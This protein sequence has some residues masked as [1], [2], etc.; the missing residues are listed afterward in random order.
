MAVLLLCFIESTVYAQCDC[1]V[2]TAAGTE[3]DVS[4]FAGGP[5]AN[6]FF[7][8]PTPAT[9]TSTNTGYEVNDGLV[10][11]LYQDG[12]GVISLLMF[13]DAFGNGTAGSGSLTVDCLGTGTVG[14]V[15]DAGSDGLTSNGMGGFGG[16]FAW[17][18]DQNDGAVIENIGCGQTFTVSGDFTGINN[19]FVVGAGGSPIP[20]GPA[21]DGVTIS[22]G[23][24]IC[25]PSMFEVDAT[26]NQ[27][28]CPTSQDGAIIATATGGTPPYQYVL[29]D[30]AGNQISIQFPNGSNPAVFGGLEEG[31]YT[32]QVTDSQGNLY[33][34][35]ETETEA[36][37]EAQDLPPV[38]NPATVLGCTF[39]DFSA[40]VDL[41]QAEDDITGNDPNLSVLWYEDPDLMFPIPFPPLHTVFGP[42]PTTVYAVATNGICP[43]EPVPIT[44]D[45][46][47]VPF[48]E[49][50]DY[51]EC[52]LGNTSMAT[53]DL[54]EKEDSIT[55]NNVAGG[56]A[57]T[58]N[59]FEDEN[60]MDTIQTPEM[61]ETA[62]TT[63]YVT[64]RGIECESDPVPI[65]LIVLENP[66]GTPD[67]LDECADPSG[68]A[69][70]DLLAAIP[71]IYND[72]GTVT[73]YEDDMQVDSIETPGSYMSASTTV[74]AFITEG[75]CISDPIPVLLNAIISPPGP[76]DM[77]ALCDDGMGMATFDLTNI[78]P[79]LTGSSD[80]IRWYSDAAGTM[81]IADPSMVTAPDTTVYYS[82]FTEGCE[83]PLA[84]VVLD[85]VPSPLVQPDTLNAC[86]DGTGVGFF[87]LTSADIIT[88]GVG[89]VSW[90]E[91]AAQTSPI[92]DPAS[93]TSG[94]TT[95]YAQAAQDSCTSEV[96]A[97]ELQIL[98]VDVA[99]GFSIT[100]CGDQ[101][102]F[103]TFDLTAVEDSIYT[104]PGTVSWFTDPNQLS[105]IANPANFNSPSSTVYGFATEDT[106]T[107]VPVPV[108]LDVIVSTPGPD[109]QISL[110]DDGMGTAEF[111]LT[112][113]EAGLIGS[114]DSLVWYSDAAA[115]VPVADPTMVSTGST[116]VYYTLF[117]QGCESPPSEVELT[118]L[119]TPLVQTDTLEACDDGTGQGSYDLTAANIITNGVGSL[120]W[121]EDAATN[122]P[123]TGDLADYI[124]SAG[125]IYVQ[126][127]EGSCE[128]PV[129]PVELEL[130]VAVTAQSDSLVLCDEGTGTATF[131]LRD[132]D[133]DIRSGGGGNVNWFTD[134]A[135]NNLIPDPTSYESGTATIYANVT[136]GSCASDIVPVYL[137]VTPLPIANDAS[138]QSCADPVTGEGTFDLTALEATVSGGAG[139]VSWFVDGA[140]TTNVPD[141][142]NVV[143][144]DTI[145]YATV[146][147]GECT[148]L[149]AEISL[150]VL[151][152]PNTFPDTLVAC[153]NGEGSASFDLTTA[154]VTDTP[155]TTVEWFQDA[156]AST[157]V[158]TPMDYAS[159]GETVYAVVSDGTCT[160]PPVAVVLDAIFALPPE[161]TCLSTGNDTVAFNWLMV[162][163]SFS[164]T[165]N[166]NGGPDL[167]PFVVTDTV[168]GVGS[169]AQG[170][171]VNLTVEALIDPLCT[172]GFT[173]TASCLADVCQPINFTYNL[174]DE[175]CADEGTIA[176]SATP[177]GGT[178]S[179]DGVS[180]NSLD[181]SGLSGNSFVY[182]DYYDAATDCDYRDSVEIEVFEPLPA[183]PV[184]CSG[185]TVNE[186]T[187]DWDDVG[188]DA[189]EVITE[190]NGMADTIQ[191]LDLSIT[192]DGLSELTDVT[193]TVTPLGPPPCGNGPAT[194]ETCTTL[195]C[196]PA[197]IAGE[198]L[199]DEYC[200]DTSGVMLPD[201]YPG[202]TYAGPGVSGSTFDPSA[203]GVDEAVISFS[204][205][206]T[207]NGC[208]YILEDT[209]QLIDPLLPP[210]LEC[211]DATPN[212]VT[213]SWAGGNPDGYQYY[214]QVDGDMPTAT[215]TTTDTFLLVTGISDVQDVTIYVSSLGQAPC[216]DSPFDSLTCTSAPCPD[217][218]LSIPNLL[219]EYCTDEAAF[220]LQG[221]PSGGTFSG[222]GVTGDTFDPATAGTGAIEIV[223]EYTDPV[224]DCAY[225]D[226][227]A[228][229]L[230]EPLEQPV[231]VCGG[232]TPSST[233]FEWNDVGADS[234]A[235]SWTIDGIA[236]GTDTVT[237]TTYSITGLLPVQDVVMTVTA[238][239]PPPCGDAPPVSLNC[240]T[241]PCPD[242][243]FEFTA[244]S[245]VCSEDAVLQLD[246]NVIGSS[247]TGNVT[248]SGSGIVSA[249]GQFDPSQANLGDNSILIE[250][251]DGVCEYDTTVV[252]NV[253]PQPQASFTVDGSFCSDSTL[254]LTFDGSATD[255]AT[256]NWELDGGTIVNELPGNVLEVSWPGP[257][258]YNLS[259]QIEDGGCVSNLFELPVE[260]IAP[261]VPPVISCEADGYTSI[262]FSWPAVAGADMYD[263]TTS[264]GTG[265]L[266]DTTYTVTGLMPGQSTTVEV[267]A[268]GTTP[269]GP[270][271][272]SLECSTPPC[273]D[274]SFVFTAPSP[275]CSEDMPLQLTT[276]VNNSNPEG[277]V[278][279]SGDGITDADGTF[280]P[281]Q[282]NLGDNLITITYDEA[283][284]CVFDTTVVVE[285]LPQPQA[286]F[287]VDGSFCSD[288]TLIL[289]FDGSATDSATFN[290]ALDGGT[291]VN[292][293]PGNVL[294]V[295][296][297]GPGTYN[298]SLQIED[299]GCVSNLFELPV[300]LIA[301][302]VPPVIS[303][304]PLSNTEILFTWNAVAGADTYDISITYGDGQATSDT[305]Y[306]VSGLLPQESSEITVV[307]IGT[308]P[309]GPVQAS[310]ECSTPPCV[311]QS[312]TLSGP[313]DVC[314]GEDVTFTI[315]LMGGSQGDYQ[316]NYTLNGQADS[317]VL[318]SPDGL[319]VTFQ[320]V[321]DTLD[322]ELN[323]FYPIDNPVCVYTLGDSWQTNVM[324]P[325]TAGSPL[326]NVVLCQAT[327]SL[328]VLESLLQGETPG[329]TWALD[330]G[331]APG[332]DA[333]GGTQSTAAMAPGTYTY[334]YTASGMGICPDSEAQVGIVINPT[335]EVE[336]GDNQELSCNM[337]M[338]SLG[339]GSNPDGA[340]YTYT[341][342]S[343]TPGVVIT[344]PNTL[345]LETGQPGVYTLSVVDPNGCTNSDQVEAVANLDA[346]S[347]S[348]SVSAPSCHGDTDGTINID[349]IAGGV[350]PFQIEL[351]GQSVGSQTSFFN[352]EDGTYT[353]KVTGDN[354]CF[355]EQDFILVE[356]DPMTAN[357][358]T[359]IDTADELVIVF[360]DSL[361]LT[362]QT[363][364]PAPIDT[365]LWEPQGL[366][367]SFWFAPQATS[368]VNLT[369]VD[370]NGCTASDQIRVIVE[371]V[372]DVFVPN[373]FSPND[374]GRNDVFYIQ[375]GD[376]VVEIESFSVYNRWGE[377]VHEV[378]NIQ[379]NDPDSG[380]DGTHR[381][382]LM[383]SGVFVWY[384][385]IR[386]NDGQTAIIKGDVVLMR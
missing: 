353:V 27:P 288:S 350:P 36:C 61:Y 169:L 52:E 78:E 183:T 103:S 153:D 71:N 252:V 191:T 77:I 184:S 30:E 43:S 284:V 107:S 220:T 373:I 74:Y 271:S 217:V 291:I 352:L 96:V 334:T 237:D 176:L 377:P 364:S 270:V 1:T 382:E 308:T 119:P 293:L 62:T 384:A 214:Y 146:F 131:N 260:L 160:A 172:D 181:L 245:P 243:S 11:M 97:V 115:T 177:S 256:F 355:A 192:V 213:F 9:S 79:G 386:Y 349:S 185:I 287:T 281:V 196:P 286:S 175:Y 145:V 132:A 158:L 358:S 135:G 250:Y 305:S 93:F 283:G 39:D 368:L 371:K 301:P 207:A 53:F 381:G 297:P 332:F 122:T 347:P 200:S 369:V 257:G 136:A 379:A 142:A 179:G 157:P 205:V 199:A 35:C 123:I 67:T 278:T 231:L 346:P 29:L 121:Y 10:V 7:G 328:V 42:F 138:Q 242:I 261:L 188:A 68:I 125:T 298:L 331:N 249:D 294:E 110:C 144:T 22:C 263:V 360:G 380:W 320:N 69:T 244:P 289:T 229:T 94:A 303:C 375:S 84:E 168:F 348:F 57:L 75:E 374:D 241:A 354:G 88:N 72:T 166:V 310:L 134:A 290:W 203:A 118:A 246:V 304:D 114:S 105:A 49:E 362:A 4:P 102:G 64:L 238:Q 268:I 276:T 211:A 92:T 234:Y 6:T 20:I 101:S 21:I 128:S 326:A 156:A 329:G 282:A 148:S 296:W 306:L 313:Q 81:E 233:S 204:F 163:D 215:T 378:T 46:E 363:N 24:G 51:F 13:I 174:T 15:N 16:N 91:D 212:S 34:G 230:F 109:D 95:V 275:V 335:P 318:S 322:F 65:D 307:A 17:P 33:A 359:S 164:V 265:T 319:E 197:P 37:L 253:H 224:T 248:W 272:S 111:D 31:C 356:P 258:T 198:F 85:P 116:T 344:N 208:A 171:I 336:A 8:Y 337:G 70:F 154:D 340:G 273:P 218:P 120:D 262:V 50:V 315:M 3:L 251:V 126:A 295:S 147:D 130:I 285:V 341:W 60:L 194:T 89:T 333:A 327:D 201:L 277:V 182:Y 279:W 193:V 155:G 66:E 247:P 100:Q 365:F 151:P 56:P 370:I 63:V 186:I 357:I 150:E 225:A 223:Y 149:P 367:K 266:S 19:V 152:L 239:G 317:V 38:A 216:G 58:V 44:V 28:T 232:A 280:D 236:A 372:R 259:L 112:S 141:P 124:S 98:S 41:T 351:N 90:Y 18:D 338:V 113:I 361:L 321:Q 330:S 108:T 86:E 300:E 228:T 25:C 206:D 80:S 195:P 274:I 162:A 299:G 45:A 104:G 267:T 292:E 376:Q 173:S 323:S 189:Y 312:A 83:S 161:A 26:L 190:V 264:A 137:V 255:S 129:I 159:T 5:D 202:G 314:Q 366:G 385:E 140:L 254:I 167:G 178:F 187:F 59:W 2:T 14:A 311:P 210:V 55:I 227:F 48:A 23:P 325:P 240:P 76:P 32:V 73:F 383:N 87:D 345:I 324:E 117:N 235:L 209:A 269:C 316:F 40:E 180:G 12:A 82:L 106:C 165:Y 127:V 302:L 133:D 170:D 139:D 339:S 343:Q 219:A 309:C 99:D 226:T 143:T 222:P 342:S 221:D 54:T 47:L